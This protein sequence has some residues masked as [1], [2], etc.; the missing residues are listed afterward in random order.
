MF[1]PGSTARLSS[2]SLTAAGVVILISVLLLMRRLTP[3][4][5][6]RLLMFMTWS[7]SPTFAVAVRWL[8]LW[9]RPPTFLRFW[10]FTRACH[11]IFVFMGSLT[12]PAPFLLLFTLFRVTFTPLSLTP[13]FPTILWVPPVPTPTPVPPF[14]PTPPFPTPTPSFPTPTS[15]VPTPTSLF[16]TSLFLS[17][18]TSTLPTSFPPFSFSTSTP[19][20]TSTS[21]PPFTFPT[22]T[23]TIPL[24]LLSNFFPFPVLFFFPMFFLFPF[25]TWLIIP[26]VPARF[27]TFPPSP[28]RVSFFPLFPTWALIFPVFPTRVNT[29]PIPFFSPTFLI[30]FMPSRIICTLSLFFTFMTLLPRI[31]IPYLFCR[32]S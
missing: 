7:F 17:T 25:P 8:R 22:P 1:P 5:F 6:C 2:G 15:P 11:G 13:I 21:F 10:L 24:F 9:P 12:R 23:P 19:F 3:A 20:P 29:V 27:N 4:G 32:M 26:S 28:T 18:P 14:L 30:L 31:P 16:P